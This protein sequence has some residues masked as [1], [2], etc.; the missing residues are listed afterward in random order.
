MAWMSRAL[1]MWVG[2]VAAGAGYMHLQAARLD[3][4]VSPVAAVQFTGQS[5]GGAAPATG[6]QPVQTS[7]AGAAPV[8][9]VAPATSSPHRTL[10]TRYCFSCHNQKLKTAGLALDTLDLTNIAEN[11]EV[12][13]KVVWKLRGGIMPPVN[14]PRPDR[15]SRRRIC[16]VPRG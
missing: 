9:P 2:L 1:A 6:T 5:A 10:L 7:Q 15:R 11:S 4:P 16:V 8:A 14:R 3:A 13:E 12:W